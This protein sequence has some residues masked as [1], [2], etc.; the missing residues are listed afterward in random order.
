MSSRDPQVAAIARDLDLASAQFAAAL[1]R[2]ATLAGDMIASVMADLAQTQAMARGMR[3]AMEAAKAEARPL[4]VQAPVSGRDAWV[5]TPARDALVRRTWATHTDA[6]IRIAVNQLPAESNVAT[7][8]GVNIRAHRL[9]CR[10]RRGAKLDDTPPAILPSEAE[11]AVPA[12]AAP[13]PAGNDPLIP[14]AVP[15][16]D[17]APPAPHIAA[18]EPHIPPTPEP[19]VPASE[20]VAGPVLLARNLPVADPPPRPKITPDQLAAIRAKSS[21]ASGAG[22]PAD[23]SYIRAWAA[24]RGLTQGISLDLA[25]INAKRADLGL[26]PFVRTDGVP[27]ARRV[28]APA[29]AG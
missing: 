7:P 25:K 3:E 9:G 8:K 2:A 13:D 28:Q 20:V 24:E 23:D 27:P 10:R 15:G 11:A 6:A 1:R 26:P 29:A 14:P 18:P 16:P 22:Q 4:K 19:H 12:Q 5:W 17:V 21:R